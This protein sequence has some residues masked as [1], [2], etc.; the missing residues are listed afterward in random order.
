MLRRK[1]QK[2]QIDPFGDMPPPSEDFLFF[3]L[4][5]EKGVYGL[6]ALDFRFKHFCYLHLEV[7]RWNHTVFKE[8][9]RDWVFAKNIIRSFGCSMVVLT[10][11]GNLANQKSYKKLIKSFGFPEPTECTISSQEI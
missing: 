1:E 9:K 6:S 8:L 2:P 11:A 3:E 5:D 7:T 4:Y 10:K